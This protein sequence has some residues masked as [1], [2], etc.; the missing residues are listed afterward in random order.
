[1]TTQ[2]L[3]KLKYPIGEFELPKTITSNLLETWITD[4]E[5]LPQSLKTLT[6]SLTETEL[7]YSYRPEGWTIKQVTHHYADS[8][9][10]SIIRFKW[11]LTENT[12]TIKFYHED[13]WAQLI[14]YS[15]SIDS[16][17]SIIKGIHA[18]LG[19]LLRNLTSEDLKREFIHPE[20]NKH[21]SLEETIG[22][23]AWHSNHHLAHIEQ[24]LRYKGEF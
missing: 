24:A 23:Y 21:F 22:V 20:H 1:M 2:E 4:I 18:K 3:Y 9:M 17:L 5:T 6:K 8:H 7:N 12:P 10:N 14:D 16:S 19:I 15:A 11:A 13:R